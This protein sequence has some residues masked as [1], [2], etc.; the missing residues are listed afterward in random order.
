MFLLALLLLLLLLL[1]QL[2][3][4]YVESLI[5]IHLKQFKITYFTPGNTE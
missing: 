4:C 5:A 2:Q 3:G 1:P